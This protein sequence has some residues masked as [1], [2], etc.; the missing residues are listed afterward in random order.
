MNY[1]ILLSLLLASLSRAAYGQ[2]PYSITTAELFVSGTDGYASYR[3]PSL[4]TTPAG[5]LLAFCEG[6][7]NSGSD[8]GNIDLLLKRSSDN[9]VSWSAFQ[10]VWNDRTNVCGNPC[11]VVDTTTGTIFLLMTWNRG[12]DHESDIIARTSRD[13]RRVF[14]TQSSD[15][16]QSWSEPREITS[17]VK[18]PNWGWYATGPG[19]GIQ[20]KHGKHK[21]RLVIPANHSY[22][23]PQG[24]L[25]GGPYEYGA[26]VIYSDDLGETWQ[27]GGQ[28]RPKM[29]ESQLVEI[30]DGRGTLAMNMR[31]YF[32]RN[33]RAQAMSRDGGDSW[34]A[35]A[36]IPD[37]V[38]PVCQASVVRYSWPDTNQRSILLF[39]NPASVSRVN[40]TVKLS[41]DEGKRWSVGRAL[42][43]GPAAYSSLAT[44]PDGKIACLYEAGKDNP[45]EALHLAIFDLDWL[46][47]PNTEE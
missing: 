42:H 41:Y 35:P 4:I 22:D 16:G 8:T 19:I 45:Y 3:I 2:T 47:S 36:D 29:N 28:I 17:S 24:D 12:D 6:R 31:S 46:R 27:V 13:T 5:T 20:I 37:L 23:D 32:G 33:R 11:P 10:V 34:T 30:A 43:E 21:G 26:H 15:E 14:V 40:M 44:L 1:T 9:G 18:P 7:K 39:S 25:R 38:E